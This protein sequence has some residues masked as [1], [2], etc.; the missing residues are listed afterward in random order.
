MLE[1][2]KIIREKTGAGMVDIKKALTEAKGDEEK[3][4]EI[5]RKSGQAKAVKKIGRD[6]K[7]GIVTCYIHSNN[8]VGAMVKLLCETDFVGRNSDF[9]ALAK[10][11]AMHIAA[12]NPKFLKPEDVTSD[13]VE[14]E[15][16]IWKEQLKKEAE[17]NAVEDQKKKELIEVRNM[18]D[19][20]IY[21]SEKSLKDAE[22]K[23]SAE[24]KTD[25]EAKIGELKKVKDGD[26]IENIKA[27]SEELSSVIQKIG[28][29]VYGQPGGTQPGQ[30][31]ANNQNE[32]PPEAETE[33]DKAN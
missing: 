21:V 9:Q 10:D 18:A 29:Q 24:I 33:E 28:E 22:G 4:I 27:R 1:K 19:N 17:T 32:E 25:I 14:K 11:I 13:F 16:E 2:I 15:K 23:I 12:M 8:R 7:E 6:A 31:Q 30:T 26:N 20:L 3:A 5:L